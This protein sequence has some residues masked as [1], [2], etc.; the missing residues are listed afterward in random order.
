MQT[1]PQ[2]TSVVTKWT[3]DIGVSLEPLSVMTASL[4]SR[5]TQISSG[6]M[7]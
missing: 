5:G 4:P 7:A 2:G 6:E 1:G 3:N